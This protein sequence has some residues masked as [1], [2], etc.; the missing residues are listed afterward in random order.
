MTGYNYGEFSPRNYDFES[1]IGPDVGDK[2]PS[3]TLATA[4]GKTLDLLAFSGDFLVLEMGS[5]TCPLFHSRRPVMQTLDDMARVSTAVLYVREAHPG[6][7]IQSHTSTAQ[8]TSCAVRLKSEDGETRTVF[9]DDLDGTAHTAYG[10][11][12]NAVFI[13]NKRGCV[14]YRTDWNNPIATKKALLALIDGRAV[15]AKSYFRPATPRALIRTLGNA[16]K[17]SAA[18]FFKGLPILIWNNI[19]K[20]NLRLFLN[21]PISGSEH[22]NC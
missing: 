18:D 5:I 2:A 15:T 22:T 4:D 11:M 20:R 9:V 1:I 13:I 6:A 3:F 17:G 14:V 10:S 16:G 8:K 7:D 19:F 21:R 12:P